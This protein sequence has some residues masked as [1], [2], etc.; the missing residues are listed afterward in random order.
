MYLSICMLAL[1]PQRNGELS[2]IRLKKAVS[3]HKCCP[4]RAIT[5]MV[6]LHDTVTY[7]SWYCNI[8]PHHTYSTY[9]SCEYVRPG[10]N[11]L[12]KL[13]YCYIFKKMNNERRQSNVY[14]VE[15]LKRKWN[16][17]N[18]YSCIIHSFLFIFIFLLDQFTLFSNLFWKWFWMH[19]LPVL[20]LLNTHSNVQLQY[21]HVKQ[22]HFSVLKE[23][24][25]ILFITILAG[26][27]IHTL[28]YV[29]KIL[30]PPKSV[31]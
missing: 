6:V 30:I 27:L 8:F 31:F 25:E 14:W 5:V 19:D 4:E 22:W 9:M 7:L 11:K 2:L 15:M 28:M 3:I 18:V 29:K 20:P 13:C 12:R 26:S 10:N 23:G 21:L 16:V 1:I 17:V 24:Y